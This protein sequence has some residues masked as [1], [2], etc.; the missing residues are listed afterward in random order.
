MCRIAGDLNSRMVQQPMKLSNQ[1]IALIP[2]QRPDLVVGG[3]DMVAGQVISLT[4]EEIKAM[5]AGWAPHQASLAGLT[6]PSAFTIVAI[7]MPQRH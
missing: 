7:T 5:W 4:K 3:G 1:A 6:C 2:G